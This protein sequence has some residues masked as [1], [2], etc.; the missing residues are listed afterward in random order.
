M[1]CLHFTRPERVKYI[2]VHH[3]VGDAGRTEAGNTVSDKRP[4]VPDAVQP[5]GKEG[6][7]EARTR[8]RAAGSIPGLPTIKPQSRVRENGLHRM[9]QKLH[10]LLGMAPTAML[11][12]LVG[13]LVQLYA[14]HFQ[15][16]KCVPSPPKP[17]QASTSSTPAH[18]KLYQLQ[19]PARTIVSDAIRV[20]MTPRKLLRPLQYLTFNGPENWQ[21]ASHH[22]SPKITCEQ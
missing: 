8:S 17:G 22:S 20:P 1:C 2:A 7:R 13:V 4:R 19:F 9:C 3:P 18:C 14:P 16:S 12:S 21:A 10:Q 5:R 11:T 6:H 15:S